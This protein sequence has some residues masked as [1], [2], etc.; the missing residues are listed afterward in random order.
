MSLV[1]CSAERIRLDADTSAEE[2]SLGTLDTNTSVPLGAE[3]IRRSRVVDTDLNEGTVSAADGVSLVAGET[4]TVGAIEGLAQRI[5]LGTEAIVE[6]GV[7]AA[8]V[9]NISSPP[10][11]EEISGAS[12][13]GS[14]GDQ[15]A[16]TALESVASIAGVAPSVGIVESLA[17]RVNL[18][19]NSVLPVGI[20]SALGAFSVGVKDS[21]KGSIEAGSSSGSRGSTSL[22]TNSV[23][24][25][26]AST[27]SGIIPGG[28]K[29]ID[30]LASTRASNE[31]DGAAGTNSLPP[32]STTVVVGSIINPLD[33]DD[34]LIVPINSWVPG[35]LGNSPSLGFDNIVILLPLGIDSWVLGGNSESSPLVS[36]L[37]VIINL[38]DGD[39]SGFDSRVL[40][41]SNIAPWVSESNNGDLG[42]LS[43][44]LALG[45]LSFAAI[46]GPSLEDVLCADG[47][48]VGPGLAVRFSATSDD[49][50][51]EEEDDCQ[52]LCL[53]VSNNK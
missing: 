23:S 8:L 47:L 49:D 2:G 24:L 42:S 30:G 29:G 36:V 51:D 53:H 15:S 33:N 9:A 20:D 22:S 38:G 14:K 27:L 1:E 52:T 11:A 37:F 32:L 31:P 48:A 7:D 21:A 26:A 39:H 45:G 35:W 28:T 40:G 5:D 19:A 25:V 13:I 10:G 17:V 4:S 3:E 34:W 43:P 50:S 44:D 41:R 6:V 16:S 12:G 46:I 18:P